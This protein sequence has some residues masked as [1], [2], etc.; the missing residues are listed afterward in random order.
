M[1]VHRCT[2]VSPF[3]LV[4]SRPPRRWLIEAEP[5]LESFGSHAQFHTKW[6]SWL[7]ALVSTA[8][9]KNDREQPR[10]KRNDDERLRSDGQDLRIGGYAFVRKEYHE[11][12]NP[13]HKL[14]Q[15]ADGPFKIVSF[16]DD[17]VLLKIGEN[18]ERVSRDRVERAPAPK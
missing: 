18:Q 6:T 11:K 17:A 9:A 3:D 14:S 13:K 16:S 10:M 2:G 7:E 5:T 8:T 1:Q 15:I 4:L 12:D